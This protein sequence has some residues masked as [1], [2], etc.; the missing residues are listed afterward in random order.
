MARES[1]HIPGPVGTGGRAQ[2]RR[3][4]AIG[5]VLVF[6]DADVVVSRE[7][8]RGRRDVFHERRQTAA[9]FGAYDEAPAIPGF[10][11]QYKNLVAFLHPS[12]VGHEGD[13]RSGRASARCAATR[14]DG[15]AGSTNASLG[16]PSKTSIS[17]I[18]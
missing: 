13:G 10:M 12:H 4:R 9:V 3:G 11:S 8:G 14:F 17:A 16:R 5:D 6:V 18:A 2:P 7:A 15:S 1:L